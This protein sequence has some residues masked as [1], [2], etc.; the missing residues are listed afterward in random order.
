VKVLDELEKG[1][2]SC[3]DISDTCAR[4]HGTADAWTTM[5]SPLR[6]DDVQSILHTLQYD[7]LIEVAHRAAGEPVYRRVPGAHVLNPLTKMP[8]GLCPVCAWVVCVYVWD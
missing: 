4:V 2:K 6:A 7:A 5:E 8:C 3:K 1:P